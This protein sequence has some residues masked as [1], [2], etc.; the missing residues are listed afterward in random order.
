MARKHRF[1]FGFF[2]VFAG[3]LRERQGRRWLPANSVC[4]GRFNQ[5]TRQPVV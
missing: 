2:D 3:R 4:C 1:R 5:R